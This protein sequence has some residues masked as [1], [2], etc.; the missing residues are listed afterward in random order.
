[1]KRWNRAA[2]WAVPLTLLLGLSIVLWLRN[3]RRPAPEAPRPAPATVD[4]RARR[5]AT[6]ASEARHPAVEPAGEPLVEPVESSNLTLRVRLL[7][8][9]EEPVGDVRVTLWSANR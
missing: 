6:A 3:S 8:Y 9:D 4:L 1:M 2:A 7:D 5:E